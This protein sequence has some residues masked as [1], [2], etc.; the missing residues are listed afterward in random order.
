MSKK[1]LAIDDEPNNL[2]A[3]RLDLE[4][5]NYE[6]LTAKGG[7]EGWKILQ[8]NKEN[9]NLILLDRMMPNMN[10]IEF[11]AKLRTNEKLSNIP[12]IMQTAAAEKE[13]IIEGIQAGA[14][15]Y[16]VKPYD[17]GVMLS[18]VKAAIENYGQYTKITQEL[19]QFKN[20]L[21]IIKDCNFEIRTINDAEYLA[22]FLANFFPDPER[23]V[24]G[25]SELLINAIEH[26]NLGISYEDKAELN[27]NGT[28]LQEVEYRLTLP[29]NKNKRVLT[30]YEKSNNEIT[31]TI[32]DEGAGFDWQD[33]MDISPERATHPHG[34]GIAMSRIISFDSIKYIGNGN[35]VVCKILQ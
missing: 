9:I 8:D 31:L 30:K 33:F 1:I 12:V 5:E 24:L 15:Y 32:T 21:H 26:G 25:I 35:K 13:Q 16:I 34:R 18:I 20:R 17:K 28:W 4:D 10:G 7:E 14:Y 29:E 23:V 6:V 19:Q 11:M 3:L 2:R 27:Y 22:T